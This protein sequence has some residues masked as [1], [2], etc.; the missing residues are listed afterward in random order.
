MG[1][2]SLKYSKFKLLTYLDVILA[3]K[4]RNGDDYFEQSTEGCMGPLNNPLGSGVIKKLRTPVMDNSS[5]N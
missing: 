5:I 2:L 3:T 4:I 1:L